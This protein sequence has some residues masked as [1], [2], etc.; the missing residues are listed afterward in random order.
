[1]VQRFGLPQNLQQPQE[2]VADKVLQVFY[3]EHSTVAEGL[4]GKKD[5]RYQSLLQSKICSWM[6]RPFT[7]QLLEVECTR[8]MQQLVFFNEGLDRFTTALEPWTCINPMVFQHCMLV[9]SARS[10]PLLEFKRS[11]SQASNLEA[12]NFSR[13]CHRTTSKVLRS[14]MTTSTWLRKTVLADGT[15]RP[16]IGIIH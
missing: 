1:M 9:Y 3:K 10:Q 16:T 5:G 2:T 6:G 13:D 7:S 14:Q 4:I 8:S 11:T 15:S 12:V